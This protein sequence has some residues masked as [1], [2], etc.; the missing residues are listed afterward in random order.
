[1]ELLKYFSE[2]RPYFHEA[3]R[4]LLLICSKIQPYDDPMGSKHVAV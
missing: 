2:V 3:I 4:I 1:M